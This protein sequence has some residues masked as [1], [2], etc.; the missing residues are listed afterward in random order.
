MEPLKIFID[1]WPVG[2]IIAI[3]APIFIAAIA[4]FVALYSAHLSRKFFKLESRPY[5]WASNYGVID[6]ENRAITPVP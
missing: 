3:Y 6:H 1:N 5:L 2:N 4:V